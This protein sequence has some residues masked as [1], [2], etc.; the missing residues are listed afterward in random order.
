MFSIYS[1]VLYDGINTYVCKL[2]RFRG[3]RNNSFFHLT[4]VRQ[5]FKSQMRRQNGILCLPA[6]SVPVS[7]LE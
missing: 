7:T 1:L 3:L 2:D 5:F 6:C 4:N